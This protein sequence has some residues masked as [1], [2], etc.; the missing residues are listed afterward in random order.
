MQDTAYKQAMSLKTGRGLLLALIMIVPGWLHAQQAGLVLDDVVQQV[1]LENPQLQIGRQQVLHAEALHDQADGQFDWG[2]YANAGLERRYVPVARGDL[3]TTGSTLSR[4][5]TTQ[6]GVRK[7]FQNGVSIGPG[8]ALY[9]SDDDVEEAAFQTVSRP[10]VNLNIPLMR[11][12]GKQVV[13]A[14]SNAAAG[15]VEAV[16]AEGRYAAAQVLTSAVIAYWKA[17]AATERLSVLERAEVPAAAFVTSL[18]Q[19]VEQG[20]SPPAVHDQARADLMLRHLEI[21]QAS[22]ELQSARRQLAAALGSATFEP[23]VTGQ[24]PRLGALR[25]PAPADDASFTRMALERRPDLVALKQRLKAQDIR[26][27]AARDQLRPKVDLSVDLEHVMLRYEQSLGQ[28]T[29]AGGV[30]QKQATLEELRLQLQQ[31]ER[32]VHTEV[33]DALALLHS[34]RRDSEQ[35]TAAVKLYLTLVKEARRKAGLGEAANSEYTLMQDRLARSHAK[36][37][38]ARLQYATALASLRLATGTTG[39]E[40]AD[41]PALIAQRFRAWNNSDE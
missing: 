40:Q 25:E 14:D 7:K 35:A 29:A 36:A 18:Q 11:G 26:L 34:A 6:M 28:R 33:R 4:Y 9:S 2:V 15:L 39:I 5:W 30:A 27:L 19:L 8:V 10:M 23:Q 41:R 12:A 3:L 32:Q 38:A 1:L 21:S 31:R 17:L 20:E 22:S 37:I 13:T 24:L 16:R